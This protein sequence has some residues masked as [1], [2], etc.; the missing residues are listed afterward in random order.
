MIGTSNDQELCI[1]CWYGG[2]ERADDAIGECGL[3]RCGR[4]CLHVGSRGEQREV[5]EGFMTRNNSTDLVGDDWL[6]Y[7]CCKEDGVMARKSYANN[8]EEMRRLHEKCIDTL[9]IINGMYYRTQME[10]Y[11]NDRSLEKKDRQQKRTKLG[12]KYIKKSVARI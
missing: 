10:T 12:I 4:V 11:G 6:F 2:D 7:L 1:Q 5:F 8:K 9:K 3:I